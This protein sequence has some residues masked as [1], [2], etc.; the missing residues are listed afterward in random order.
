MLFTLFALRVLS[1][2][3]TTYCHVAHAAAEAVHR[4]VHRHRVRGP[5]LRHR[6]HAAV[7]LHEGK[8]ENLILEIGSEGQ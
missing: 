8:S 5:M 3:G 7:R 2:N 6:R 1:F 4:L